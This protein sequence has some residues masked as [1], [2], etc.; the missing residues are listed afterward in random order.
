MEGW[1]TVQKNGISGRGTPLP[2]I[3]PCVPEFDVHEIQKTGWFADV[4]EKLENAKDDGRF[5]G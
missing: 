5:S 1:R 2:D 3:R 4:S